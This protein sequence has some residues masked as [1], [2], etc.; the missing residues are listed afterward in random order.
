MG[1][2]SS[3]PPRTAV[4]TEATIQEARGQRYAVD[5]EEILKAKGLRNVDVFLCSYDSC[6]ILLL[7]TSSTECILEDK[8][9]GPTWRVG[10]RSSPY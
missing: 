10:F 6:F 5:K 9:L 4:D 1:Y 7:T 2:F 3:A 8:K